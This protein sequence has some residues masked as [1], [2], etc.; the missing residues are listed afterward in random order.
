MRV[1]RLATEILKV[2][3]R[4][5]YRRHRDPFGV[6]NAVRGVRLYGDGA[7]DGD[8]ALELGVGVCIHPGLTEG[9]TPWFGSPTPPVPLAD[10]E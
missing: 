9:V 3:T 10:G 5:E 7:S 6:Y 1:Y 2:N 8:L 4:N